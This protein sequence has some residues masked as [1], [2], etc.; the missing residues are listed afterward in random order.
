VII[1]NG[2]LGQRLQAVARNWYPLIPL[3]RRASV[4]TIK[5]SSFS[6]ALN[7]SSADSTKRN[8]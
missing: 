5:N 2:V 8:S 6:R 4:M 7:A 3:P 1:K